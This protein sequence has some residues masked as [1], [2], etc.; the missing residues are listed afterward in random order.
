ME[1]YHNKPLFLLSFP[2]EWLIKE[3]TRKR[4][5]A[6]TEN[7]KKFGYG[8]TKSMDNPSIIKKGTYFL[9]IDSFHRF[10]LNS[11]PKTGSSTWRFA[12]L[13]NSLKPGHN[14]TVPNKTNAGSVHEPYIFKE[15]S[16]SLPTNY[17]S[18]EEV[19]KAL[20]TYYN[21]L[22]VRHPFD[23]LESCFIEKVLL[24]TAGNFKNIMLQNRNNIE[25]FRHLGS[26]ELHFE[27]FL[28]FIRHNDNAHWASVFSLTSPCAVPFRY[29]I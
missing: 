2:T 13:N 19:L 3:T 20:E 25:M 24:G 22:T 8:H 10:T 14:V 9:L 16:Y 28:Y 23:R 7:C 11:A 1:V 6:L 12:L 4:I 21:V 5:N 29:V 26:E 17:F 18:I 27:E 15:K